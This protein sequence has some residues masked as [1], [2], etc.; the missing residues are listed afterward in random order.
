MVLE[1]Y[2]C[3]TCHAFES[4]DRAEVEQHEDLPISDIGIEGLILKNTVGRYYVFKKADILDQEHR[5]HYKADTVSEPKKQ[6]ISLIQEAE[7]MD[8]VS[9]SIM[10]FH[11]STKKHTPDD[12]MEK[13]LLESG[14]KVLESSSY[15]L[16]FN[17]ASFQKMIFENNL[18]ELDKDEIID[19]VLKIKKE[20][21]EYYE[22]IKFQHKIPDKLL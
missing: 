3:K 15:K 2:I 21:P 8:F 7:I 14:W 5:V 18:T 17:K 20:N 10:P 4:Y 1:K 19:I 16:I 12:A 13:R 6:V 9:R 11:I 22:G